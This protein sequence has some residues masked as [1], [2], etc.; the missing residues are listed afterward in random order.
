MLLYVSITHYPF[1][2]DN[3]HVPFKE[4][5]LF[6]FV[7]LNIT[8]KKVYTAALRTLTVNIWSANSLSVKATTT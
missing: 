2:W 6:W 4:H 1:V 3:T 5:V 7:F 8:G